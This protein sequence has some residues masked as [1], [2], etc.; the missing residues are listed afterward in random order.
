MTARVQKISYRSREGVGLG[1]KPDLPDHRDL[2]IT[3]RPHMLAAP[4]QLQPHVDLFEFQ[5]PVRNQK[6]E[7]SCTGHGTSSGVDFLTRTDKDPTVNDIY[8]PRW[9]YYWARYLEG[10]AYTAQD[11]GAYIRN[12]VKGAAQKGA[13][14]EAVWPYHAGEFSKKP[15]RGLATKA[16]TWRLEYLRCPDLNSILGALSSTDPTDPSHVVVGGFACH[17]GMWTP[18]ID[19]SGDMPMPGPNDKQDGGHCV[20]FCG[21]DLARKVLLFKNSWSEAWG[22]AFGHKGYGTLPFDFVTQQLADDFWAMV[23][24]KV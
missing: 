24:Q 9:A 22:N 12:A 6:S 18:A 1:W 16:A 15:A 14:P 11:G 21:Y 3:D 23:K 10:A 2:Y 5:S 4:S 7:G 20:L 17:T 8:S 13:L 19:A